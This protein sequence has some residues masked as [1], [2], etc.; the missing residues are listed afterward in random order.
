[1][2]EVINIILR[3]LDY[4]PVIRVIISFVLI[5][6]LP[7]FAWTLVFFKKLKV[8]ERI[9]FSF[10]LSLAIVTLSILVLNVLFKV[11]ITGFNS[12]IVIILATVIPLTIYY[13][14]RA[15]RK[16]SNSPL[17]IP[18]KIKGSLLRLLHQLS[19]GWRKHER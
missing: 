15:R 10:G 3:L 4:V 6:F 5:L 12:F 18:E 11:R 13:F 2:S 7:G 16:H 14:N 8:V 19:F 9:V 17:E 1:M